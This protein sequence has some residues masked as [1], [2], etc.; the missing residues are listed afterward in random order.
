VNCNKTSNDEKIELRKYK[1]SEPLIFSATLTWLIARESI[2]TFVG[3]EGFKSYITVPLLFTFLCIFS[4]AWMQD[5]NL[6]LL[7]FVISVLASLSTEAA[8]CRF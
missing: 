1:I 2:S 3:R 6:Q 5:G 4:V 7:A 8:V